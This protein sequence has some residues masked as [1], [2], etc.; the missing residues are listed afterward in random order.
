VIRSAGRNAD[1]SGKEVELARHQR[2]ASAEHPAYAGHD[3]FVK[4]GAAFAAASS[5]WYASVV[6]T[7]SGGVSQLR[8]EPSSSTESRSCRAP[9]RPHRTTLIGLGA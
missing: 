5:R 2:D 7:S 3:G 1:R 9:I 8:N 6:S 4:A